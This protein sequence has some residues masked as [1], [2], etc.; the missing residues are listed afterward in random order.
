MDADG[1][2]RVIFPMPT[3]SDYLSLAFDEIRQFGATSVQ[4][5]R[6]LRSALVG[7]AETAGTP[8]RTAQVV[9]YLKHLDLVVEQSQ[10]DPADQA[11]ARRED[12]QGLGL[13]RG[14]VVS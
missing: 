14:Q 13:S 11:M 8:A 2:L 5:M 7:L 9:A 1:V 3:W 4:V 10:L 6:R 12:R